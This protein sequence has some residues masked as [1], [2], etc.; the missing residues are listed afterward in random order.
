M[1]GILNQDI[2]WKCPSNI[3][4]VKYWGKKGKQLP[5]NP[6]VSMTLAEALKTVFL[7][8]PE[9]PHRLLLLVR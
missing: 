9:L 6:S 3:A 8:Q 4:I 2:T 7:I 5:C 1:A